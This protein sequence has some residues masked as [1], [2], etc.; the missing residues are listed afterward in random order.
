ML[1]LTCEIKVNVL[2]G[3]FGIVTDVKMSETYGAQGVEFIIGR[4]Y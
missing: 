2:N 1:E 3:P 4:N